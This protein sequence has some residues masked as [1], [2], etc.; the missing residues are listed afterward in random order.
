MHVSLIDRILSLDPAREIRTAKN[1]SYR[2]SFL[3]D[4]FASFPLMPGALQVEA[5]VQSAQWML[6]VAYDFPEADFHPV[7]FSN[8]RYARYVRP[9]EQIQFTV[10]L[11]T[12]KLG[13]SAP[14]QGD[15]GR[16]KF[17]GTGEVEGQRACQS[18]FELVRY[19]TSWQSVSRETRSEILRAQRETLAR[20]QYVPVPFAL[21]TAPALETPALAAGRSA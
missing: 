7:A 13:T 9:G 21:H 4:H 16:W 19:E 5:M 1:L 11:Q 17:K 6:R 10:T 14:E 20:L 18:Q 15:A 2:E 3:G 12:S 8:T